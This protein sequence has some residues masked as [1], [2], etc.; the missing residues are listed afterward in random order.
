MVLHPTVPLFKKQAIDY[1][2]CNA[3]DIQT[4]HA[5]TKLYYNYYTPPQ[6]SAVAQW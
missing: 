2:L 6:G 3:D 1:D 4:L 5:C